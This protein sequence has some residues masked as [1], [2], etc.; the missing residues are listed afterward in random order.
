ML[1]AD[2]RDVPQKPRIGGRVAK[3]VFH[4]SAT[5]PK[6]LPGGDVF[7]DRPPI[8]AHSNPFPSLNST[9]DFGGPAGVRS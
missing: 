1:A 6:R 5:D 8:H 3:D 9:Q 7:R 4:C 2:W